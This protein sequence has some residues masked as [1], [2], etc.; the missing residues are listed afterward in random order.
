MAAGATK[1]QKASYTRRFL[2]RV[3][4][5][6]ERQ[7]FTVERPRGKGV[8][9]VRVPWDDNLR[10]MAFEFGVTWSN[11]SNGQSVGERWVTV[12]GRDGAEPR[13]FLAMDSFRVGAASTRGFWQTLDSRTGMAGLDIAALVETYRNPRA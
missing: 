8:V 2:D 1:Q 3:Q 9:I 10:G 6:A 12:H 7:E 4:R 11:M 13:T 5:L